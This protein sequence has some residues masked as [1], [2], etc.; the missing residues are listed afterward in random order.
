MRKEKL[1]GNLSCFA[2]YAIFGINIVTCK[3][4][5]NSQLIS[6]L[7]LFTLRA[8]GASALFW[9]ISVA[10]RK[11]R[12]ESVELRDLPKIFA[13]SMLGLFITQLTFLQAIKITSPLDTSIL[14]TLSPIFTMLVA[15]V[16]IKEPITWK[17]ASGVVLSFVGILMLILSG[18]HAQTVTTTPLGVV[19]MLGNALSFA[20][21]LGIFRPLIEK[22][23]VIT[24]MKWMFLFSALVALP[25]S[26]REVIAL[27][28]AA[29]PG[30]VL[31]D[32]GF[33]VIFAT[34][35]AY[36]LIPVGQKSLRPT[37][38]SLYSYLQPI[39]ASVISIW[40]GM[41]RL[42]MTKVICAAAVITGVVIVSKSR[43]AR[44]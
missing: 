8:I 13:A 19:L 3:D 6:P 34:F 1:L 25:F 36:F 9:L 40:V 35:I 44:S 15:A 11:F 26:C 33:L 41:D 32:L 22:Y 27:N 5:A 12:S 4:L 38:V 30:A 16:A 37:I 21:Y 7:A 42:T 10:S 17:K 18:K 24:F 2:A 31:F 14:S 28:F 29:I 39:I 23:S 20:L 43:G